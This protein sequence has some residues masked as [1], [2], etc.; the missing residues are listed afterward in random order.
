MLGALSAAA[1]AAGGGEPDRPAETMPTVRLG[2]VTVSRL[3]LGSNPFWG[4]AHQPGNVGKAMK[5]YFTDERI[6]AVLEEAAR[7]GITA[8]VSPPMGRWI[9]LFAKYRAGGGKLRTWIAQPHAAP[10][11]MP[12][13]IAAAAARGATAAFIQ[14]A[15]VDEQVSAGRFDVLE[16]WLK[17]IRGLGLPAGMAS[18]RSDVH[19]EAE[20]RGLPTDF[21][22]QC[23]FPND[24]FLPEDREAALATVRKLDK[25]VVAYKVLA[26]G[27]L[28][29]AKALARAFKSLRA[30]D[31]VCIG[32]FPKTKPDMVSE[33]AHLVRE[34]S[35]RPTT[36]PAGRRGG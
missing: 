10:A 25:P 29:P 2:S 9:D 19:L 12:Q 17:Q 34:L 1:K 6:M 22:F 21:Y 28:E 24:K 36:R 13:E 15:R 26:A 35:Q 7:C 11:K 8:V 27:R 3:L 5:A 31:S 30:K 16:T 14:G 4:Y 20:K 18:H 23:L 32:V 33:D